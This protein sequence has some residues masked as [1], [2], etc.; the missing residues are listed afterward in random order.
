VFEVTK[1]P[2][3]FT[4]PVQFCEDVPFWDFTSLYFGSQDVLI[5]LLIADLSAIAVFYI[6][7]DP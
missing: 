5:W 7:L 4:L 1:K 6:S 3:V 2:K